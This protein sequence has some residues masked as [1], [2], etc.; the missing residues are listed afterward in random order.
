MEKDGDLVKNLNVLNGK[1]NLADNKKVSFRVNLASSNKSSTTKLMVFLSTDAILK[2]LFVINGLWSTN[3]AI[4]QL[5]KCLPNM[6]GEAKMSMGAE[7]T[8]PP[9]GI[10]HA[11]PRPPAW[12]RLPPE[13]TDPE[14]N[15]PIRGLSRTRQRQQVW[16]A[17]CNK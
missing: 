15:I 7:P 4:A 8:D 14:R 9:K 12:L 11:R 13:H 3:L 2:S 1:M 5:K 6:N 17:L 16:K 10:Y